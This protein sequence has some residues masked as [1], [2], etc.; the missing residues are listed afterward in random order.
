MI[1]N[2]TQQSSNTILYLLIDAFIRFVTMLTGYLYNN[3]T[4]TM[5]YT[6]IIV[7]TFSV[8]FSDEVDLSQ[9]CLLCYALN[10]FY[11][12]PLGLCTFISE[13]VTS[14]LLPTLSV[15]G[16]CAQ[17]SSL[18]LPVQWNWMLLIL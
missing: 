11:V 12:V 10:L 6:A 17:T 5:H 8:S 9:S 7:F 3:F 13:H 16:D 4:F 2:C 1:S 15:L 14:Y 18:Y